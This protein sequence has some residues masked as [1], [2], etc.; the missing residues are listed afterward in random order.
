MGGPLV[1]GLPINCR[2][3]VGVLAYANQGVQCLQRALIFFPI[4]NF[5]SLTR[6]WILNQVPGLNS[7]ELAASRG[8]K[9]TDDQS[10]R[11]PV[12]RIANIL[13][14]NGFK[15][16]F[17]REQLIFDHFLDLLPGETQRPGTPAVY[18][19]DARPPLTHEDLKKFVKRF[20]NLL[21]KLGIAERARI[22]VVLP[23]GPEVSC[24]VNDN[25]GINIQNLNSDTP[26][27]LNDIFG[28]AGR[29]GDT[30]DDGSR[31]LL[32]SECGEST[33]RNCKRSFS[34]VCCSG[35]HAGR[36]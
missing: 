4:F 21:R 2:A 31:H 34:I 36:R 8:L 11:A 13:R 29:S 17:A 23:N 28:S 26:E 7:M 3:Q 33:W 5:C 16:D 19:T 24:F 14:K 12:P 32:P 20:P 10:S 22:G 15:G 35:D 30:L 6:Y 25:V 27:L 18:S 1:R 9:A